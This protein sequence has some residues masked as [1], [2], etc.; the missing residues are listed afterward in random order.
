MKK[1]LLSVILLSSMAMANSFGQLGLG[2]A[3][4]NNSDNYVTA[5]GSIKVLS[6]IGARLEYTKNISEHASFSKEDIS[7]YGLFATYTLPLVS[8]VSL[9]PKVGLVK[10]DGAFK[11]TDTV[12]EITDSSTDFTFGLEVNYQLN[13]SISAFVGYT[14]YGD[15]LDIKDIDTS[16]LDTANYL[17]GIKI[18][19]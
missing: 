16:K 8:G 7:R 15:V 11:I 6:N 3:K 9:T 12:K 14:D 18:D 17:F 1:L 13:D 2:Y 10:T 5:F 19:L 4:G